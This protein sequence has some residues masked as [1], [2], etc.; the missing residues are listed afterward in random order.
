MDRD[1]VAAIAGRIRVRDYTV[2]I[3][4]LGYVGIPLALTAC[5]AGFRVIGFD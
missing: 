4:G 3:I 2:G 5:R 1:A